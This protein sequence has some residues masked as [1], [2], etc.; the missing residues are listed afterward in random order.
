MGLRTRAV[1]VPYNS[2]EDIA[3]SVDVCRSASVDFA[4]RKAIPARPSPHFPK[5]SG[6]YWSVGDHVTRRDGNPVRFI[7]LRIDDLG[8]ARANPHVTNRVVGGCTPHAVRKLSNL[9]NAMKR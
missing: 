2:T 4:W 5:V 9:A 1:R 8:R 7:K 3:D 6:R